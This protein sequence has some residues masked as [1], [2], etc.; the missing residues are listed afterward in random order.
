MT[1][2]KRVAKSIFYKTVSGWR[3]IDKSRLLTLQL[4]N[5]AAASEPRIFSEN[6]IINV[7]PCGS[8]HVRTYNFFSR[9]ICTWWQKTTNRHKHTGQLQEPSMRA[10]APND[11]AHVRTTSKLLLQYT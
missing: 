7:F 3:T 5:D 8:E 10:V 4:L 11:H 6:K 9:S 2:A 1:A